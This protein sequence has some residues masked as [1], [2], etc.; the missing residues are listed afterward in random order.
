MKTHSALVMKHVVSEYVVWNIVVLAL[1][2]SLFT[3]YC[4]RIVFIPFM[5]PFSLLRLTVAWLLIGVRVFMLAVRMHKTCITLRMMLLAIKDTHHRH[6]GVISCSISDHRCCRP[7]G[8]LGSRQKEEGLL[9]QWSTGE[10]SQDFHWHT[11]VP[12]IPPTLS[13][14]LIIPW[15]HE[16]F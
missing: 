1:Q 5:G 11:L 6:P 13:P 10:T 15:H 16:A 2:A 9:L 7:P 8:K 12:F 3:L 14:N 4:Y